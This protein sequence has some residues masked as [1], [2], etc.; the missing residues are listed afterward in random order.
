MTQITE[1]ELMPTKV[2]PA[3]LLQMA[4]QSNIGVAELEKL[5]QLYEQWENRQ[6]KKEFL[7]AFTRFQSICPEI[8]KTKEVTF[9]GK[10]QYCYAPL[11]DICRQI[12]PFLEKCNLSYRWEHSEENSIIK[13]TCI[14]SH[15]NGHSERTTMTGPA[16][17]SGSKNKIQARGSS[18][19]FLQ[20][21]TLLGALGISTADSDIDGRLPSADLDKLHN[22]YMTILNMLLKMDEKKF[23]K[24]HPNEWKM[25]PTQKNYVMAISAVKKLLNEEQNKK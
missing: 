1:A 5:T 10:V 8:R 13:V 17:E 3:N 2:T 11:A 9:S 4:I 20:R 16:D 23:S 21:Y 7:L 24:Y 12:N 6:A 22:E 19:T 25:E 18:F 15:I 14:I